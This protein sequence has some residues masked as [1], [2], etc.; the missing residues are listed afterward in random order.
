MNDFGS[1]LELYGG[2]FNVGLKIVYSFNTQSAHAHKTACSSLK[3]T[4]HKCGLPVQLLL[5]V[6]DQKGCAQF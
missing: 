4:C 3:H 1:F 2:I 6:I 5:H